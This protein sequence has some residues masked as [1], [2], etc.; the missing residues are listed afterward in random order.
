MVEVMDFELTVVDDAVGVGVLEDAGVHCDNGFFSFFRLPSYFYW[1]NRD[2]P[3]SP[4][5]L[6]VF[7][8][9]LGVLRASSTAFLLASSLVVGGG[10]GG[11]SPVFL[12]SDWVFCLMR[13]ELRASMLT[14]HNFRQI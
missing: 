9:V 13:A 2:S 14:R 3:D 7:I 10:C 4:D 5:F 12:K 11:G 1:F 6:W 8:F